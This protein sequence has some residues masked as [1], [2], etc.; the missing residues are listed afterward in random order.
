MLRPLMFKNTIDMSGG[1]WWVDP[2]FF[3][4]FL[5]VWCRTERVH[6]E[7][8]VARAEIE[9]D[10]E[11][12]NIISR[13]RLNN[14][15]K[16]RFYISK[17]CLFLFFKFKFLLVRTSGSLYYFYM[18]QWHQLITMNG[19]S[20]VHIAASFCPF[21]GREFTRKSLKGGLNDWWIAVVVI[22]DE[23]L[24]IIVVLHI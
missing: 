15:I 22:K 17:C 21:I 23:E 11:C 14:I 4:P 19:A 2:S 8:A 7:N 6:R 3:S 5:P 24:Y 10:R 12:Q 16:P 20:V 9:T 1:W 13:T 18:S